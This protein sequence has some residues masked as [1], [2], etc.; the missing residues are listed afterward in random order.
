MRC[1]GLTFTHQIHTPEFFSDA[2]DFPVIV[3]LTD[4]ER[5]QLERVV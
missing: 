2:E 5:Q 4:V 3:R 1:A